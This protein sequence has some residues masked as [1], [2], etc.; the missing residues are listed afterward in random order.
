[1]LDTLR[2]EEA[3]MKRCVPA[4]CLTVVLASLLVACEKPIV[5]KPSFWETKNASVG[6]AI[7]K[8]PKAVASKQGPQG[9]L[10]IAIN[11]AMA[12]DLKGYL[13]RADIGEFSSVSDRFVQQFQERGF[14]ARK[15]DAFV[16]LDEFEKFAPPSSGGTHHGKDLRRLAAKENVDLLLLL[17]VERFGTLRPYYGFIPLGPPKALFA[18]KGELVNLRTNDLLWRVAMKDEDALVAVEGGWDQPPDFPNLSRALQRAVEQA[19][20]WLEQQLFST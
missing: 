17:S 18:V 5:V 11:E 8:Y 4:I 16:D 6:V 12:R 15:I 14:T 19:G 7:V 9:L 13:E 1:V 2:G 3:V 20:P 10:D